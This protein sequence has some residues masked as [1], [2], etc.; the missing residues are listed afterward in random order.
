MFSI[1][2]VHAKE[3]VRG[4]EIGCLDKVDSF[5]KLKEV[6]AL[7]APSVDLT[8]LCEWLGVCTM[9]RRLINLCAD[10]GVGFSQE[11]Q[12]PMDRPSDYEATTFC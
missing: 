8:M 6:H 5:R 7:K 1:N 2:G 4:L 12:L 10:E 11:F 3:H 9:G